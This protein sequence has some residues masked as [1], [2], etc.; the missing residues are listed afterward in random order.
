MSASAA[1]ISRYLSNFAS[2]LSQDRSTSLANFIA[3]V[4][5][6]GLAHGQFKKYS[7]K[8][9]FQILDTARAVGGSRKRIEFSAADPFFNCVP[10]GLE[11]T[12]DDYERQLA[13]ETGI[14]M[15]QEARVRNLV[16]AAILSHEKKVFDIVKAAKAATGSVGVW[17]V[18]TNDPVAELDAQIEAIATATGRMPNRIVFGLGAWRIF[19]NHTLVI[20]RQ[21][22][23]DLVG[24][25]NEQAA[26]MTINPQIEVRVGIL[27]SDTTKFGAAKNA[28][29][30]VGGEVFLF[31]ASDAPDQMDASFAKTFATKPGMI[32]AVREYREE[33]AASDVFFVDW[34]EDVQVTAAECGARITLS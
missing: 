5:A 21:P 1:T 8:N 16:N 12:I 15:L 10:Q 9:D 30:I 14:G 34:S 11:T 24:I 32:D 19:R 17:S 27:S 22:G 23:A 20:K 7:S 6:T 25:T 3:P 13:G 29:N 4:V 26:R 2:G 33:R 28:V 18:A 31:F